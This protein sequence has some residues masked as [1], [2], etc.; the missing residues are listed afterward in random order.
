MSESRAGILHIKGAV[1]EMSHE[2][3]AKFWQAH[4][5]IQQ[6]VLKHREIGVV[7][8]ALV[9]LQMAYEQEQKG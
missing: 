9:T 5:D 4:S 2:E 1:T 7:A 6:T 3:Q 8:I